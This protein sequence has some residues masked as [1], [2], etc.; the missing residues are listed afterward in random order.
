MKKRGY[1]S[2]HRLRRGKRI[3][4]VRISRGGKRL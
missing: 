2:V 3:R 4:R 1:G